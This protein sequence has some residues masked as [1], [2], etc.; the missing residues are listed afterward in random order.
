MEMTRNVARQL[1][2]GSRIVAPAV[3]F[4]VLNTAALVAEMWLLSRV[5]ADVFVGHDHV[6]TVVPLLSLLALTLVLRAALVTARDASAGLAAIRARGRL[7]RRVIDHLLALG[8]AYARGERTG[9]LV[10]ATTEGIDR[11]DPY[12]SRYLPQ[13]IL[14]L[15]IPLIIA[16]AV[17]TQDWVSA[18]LLLV[19][20]PIIPLLMILVGSYAEGH[21]QQQW[22]ALARLS[23]H[24]LD[25]LQGLPTLKAFGRG[26]AEQ[27]TISRISHDFR[28]RTMRVLRFAFLSGLVLEFITAGAIALIAVTLGVRL[29]SGSISFE[30]AFFVLLLTPEYYRPLRELGQH[31][32]A[33]MEGAVSGNRLA[34]IL[35]TPVA[36]PQPDNGVPAP[37]GPIRLELD[38]VSYTY[39]GRSRPALADVSLALPVGTRTALVGRSGSGKST[40]LNVLM[41]FL[42]ATGGEILVNGV[43]LSTIAPEEWRSRISFVPQRPHLFHGSIAENIAL[44]GPEA[45][46]DEIEWA[47]ELAGAMDFI[48]SLPERTTTLIGDG[49]AR[50]SGGE[51]QRLAIARAFLKDAPLVLFDE[52]TSNLDP[53]SET[54]IRGAL[55]RLT[56][57]RTLLVVAHRL[58]TIYTA[59]NIVVLEEGRLVEQGRHADLLGSGGAY[60]RLH[61]PGRLV[62]A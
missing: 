26:K 50:L 23:A 55:E 60:S 47:A 58:N 41:G 57:G 20:A 3:V 48:Q 21:I 54:L 2:L 45:R 44:G 11:L 13:T 39:P 4:G 1:G 35:A 51:A 34:E 59:D 62:P 17:L 30:R 24:F 49:G 7:R 37:A 32:H 38:A 61:G 27:A 14:G 43:P 15:A 5:V 53:R 33:A 8:P 22:E 25:A 28:D 40:L 19:T 16:V 9:E 36:S 12:V 46:L 52:P 6:A 56:Q 18:T 42:T 10:A 31:R 29:L